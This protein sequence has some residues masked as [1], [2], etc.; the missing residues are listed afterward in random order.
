MNP[1]APDYA[2]E[3]IPDNQESIKEDV[4]ARARRRFAEKERE[5][6]NRIP[7]ADHRTTVI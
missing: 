3:Q 4:A 1:N 2:M 6:L 7:E 5:F